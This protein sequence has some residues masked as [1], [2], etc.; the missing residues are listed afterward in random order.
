MY[1]RNVAFAIAIVEGS[2]LRQS[3]D[4]FLKFMRFATADNGSK[5][6]ATYPT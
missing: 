6:Y 4:G 3:K 5:I 2:M 1:T